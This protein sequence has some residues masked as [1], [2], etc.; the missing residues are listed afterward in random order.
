MVFKRIELLLHDGQLRM[1]FWDDVLTCSRIGLYPEHLH[2]FIA[3]VVD[4]LYCDSA[5][6]RFFEGAG[7]V[8]VEGGPSVRVDLG[9]EGG[10]QRGVRIV[11]A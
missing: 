2:N 10:F 7:C 3:E 8:A 11:L 4:H 5:G 6:G 9:F 1:W